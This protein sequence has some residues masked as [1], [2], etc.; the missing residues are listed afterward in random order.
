MVKNGGIQQ[1]LSQGSALQ[2]YRSAVTGTQGIKQ[3]LLYEFSATVISVLPG[4]IGVYAR[5][6]FMPLLLSHFG[7]KITMHQNIT[8]RRPYRI[9][10]GDG[11]TLEKGVTLDVKT[12]AGRIEIQD[13]VHIGRDTILSC[14]GGTIVICSGVSIGSKCRLGSLEGLIIGPHSMIG[15][16]V[17][18]V[19]AGHAYSSNDIPIVQ[20]PLTCK[21]QTVIEDYVEIEKEVTVLD[22]IHI[23]KNA[24]VARSSLVNKNIESGCTVGGVPAFPC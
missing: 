3:F 8:V 21:G 19:G 6:L 15:D 14:P 17:C 18:I 11:V 12:D 1:Q 4:V 13:D 9:S 22:G 5:R 20:Q 2:K 10:I 7:C 24:K 23:A 16:S